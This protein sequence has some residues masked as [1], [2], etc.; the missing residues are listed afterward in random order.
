MKSWQERIRELRG[1][2]DLTQ[3]DVAALL[4]TTQQVYSRYEQGV[5]E[6]PIRYLITLCRFY[7]VDSN[8]ILGLS[9]QRIP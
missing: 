8:Y 2:H 5:N 6:L 9:E 3:R 4:G 7:K 1:D